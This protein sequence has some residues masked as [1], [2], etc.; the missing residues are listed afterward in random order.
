MLFIF[1][2]TIYTGYP[3]LYRMS[4]SP[5][6]RKLHFLLSFTFLLLFPHFKILNFYTHYIEFSEN[7]GG[8]TV[9]LA[10]YL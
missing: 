8:I 4:G 6:R 5:E 9:F 1:D 3:V 2:F 10:L 7:E